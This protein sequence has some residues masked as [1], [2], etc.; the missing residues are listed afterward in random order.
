M[1]DLKVEWSLLYFKV[2][3]FDNDDEKSEGEFISWK[4]YQDGSLVD[5]QD[6]HATHPI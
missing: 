3:E 5:L 4:T 6:E 1:K 2:L